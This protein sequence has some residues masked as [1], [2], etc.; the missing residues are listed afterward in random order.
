[1]FPALPRPSP[2]LRACHPNIAMLAFELKCRRCGWRTICGR[3]D[4]I[5]RLRLIGLLRR[6][7]DPQES[8]VA[9][10]LVESAARMTCPLC[11]EKRLVANP[12][13]EIPDDDDWQAAVVCEICRQP[14][15]P[16]RLEA[17]PGVKRCASC[18]QKSESG[19]L[20]ESE[21]EF[22]PQCGALVEIRIS[23]GSGITR[24]KRVCTGNPPCRL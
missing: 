1:M 22:C 6:D 16:E 7:P 21:P 13:E 14:I 11:K 12:A 20:R 3:D 5:A 10:L 18:Q 19:E 8:V 15:P 2:G 23:R 17:L 4:A 9:A 24:Y